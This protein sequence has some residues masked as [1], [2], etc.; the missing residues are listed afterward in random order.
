MNVSIPILCLLFVTGCASISDLSQ[1]VNNQ[2][3]YAV[4]RKVS[5]YRLPGAVSPSLAALI[6]EECIPMVEGDNGGKCGKVSIYNTA[7]T[8][9]LPALIG[10]GAAVGASVFI[11]KGL[12]KSGSGSTSI[13]NSSENQSGAGSVSSSVQEQN[14]LQVQ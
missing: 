8:G 9:Y 12:E 3:G 4:T 6:T 11:G 2:D 13:E 10:G 1:V 5:A 14:Q 7:Q